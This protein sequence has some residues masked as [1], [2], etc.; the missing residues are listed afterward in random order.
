MKE[1]KGKKLPFIIKTIHTSPPSVALLPSYTSNCSLC[2]VQPSKRTT[3]TKHSSLVNEEHTPPTSPP[4]PHPLLSVDKRKKL[5]SHFFFFF[6]AS[7]AVKKKIKNKREKKHSHRVT[8]TLSSAHNRVGV[9]NRS[10]ATSQTTR[11]EKIATRTRLDNTLHKPKKYN[12]KFQT[13][14]AVF[15]FLCAL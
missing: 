15:H 8:H 5:F 2:T 11:L 3:S 13:A 14:R 6:S 4:F 9:E 10:F 1:E 7:F 12:K